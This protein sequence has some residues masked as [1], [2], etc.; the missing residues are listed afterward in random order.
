MAKEKAS[1]FGKAI[2]M[3]F[4]E[5]VVDDGRQ[6]EDFENTI[7]GVKGLEDDVE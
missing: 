7:E 4:E 2:S 5:E 6:K 1:F 3:R